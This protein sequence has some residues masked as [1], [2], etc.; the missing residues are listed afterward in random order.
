MKLT[1]LFSRTSNGQTQTWEIEVKGNTYFTH[2]GILN[3]KITTSLPTVCK[4]KNTGKKNETT[5]ES[6][7]V[8]EAKAIWKKKIESG[9]YEDINDIDKQRFFEPMLCHKY[10][11]GSLPFSSGVYVQPKLDG[12]RCICKKDGM[13]TRNGKKIVSAPHI[14]ESL[15]PLFKKNQDLILDGELYCDKFKNDFNKII[16]LVRKSKPTPQDLIDSEKVI[17]YWIYDIPSVDKVFSDRNEALRELFSIIPNGIK[18]LDTYKVTDI[19]SMNQW[20]EK[21]L[22]EGKEGQIIRLNGMYENKRSNNILKRKEF[23][24]QEYKIIGVGEGEGNKTGMLG[25]VVVEMTDGTTFRSNIK[26][27]H[28]YL[29]ELW[30]KKT[31]L[32]GKMATIKYF[33][34]TPDGIPRFPYMMSVR[35]FE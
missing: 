12:M 10:E 14:M 22:E 16:S 11:G 21:W 26:G 13:W 30:I 27:T 7:A 8:K 15:T 20:Y 34:L 6:Q 35:D 17:E 25:F 28:E 18:I 2:E 24:D 33:N 23:I 29:K 3:G 32:I 1:K 4:G 9:Y 19:S 5:D 31:S